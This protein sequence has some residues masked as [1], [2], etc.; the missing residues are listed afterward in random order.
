[1]TAQDQIQ[2]RIAG[3]D[4]GADDFVVK[5]YDLYEVIAR[6][7][8][9]LRRI[10]GHVSDLVQIGNI[11][12]NQS[13]KQV[14]I[15]EIEVELTQKEFHLLELLIL[16]RGRIISRESIENSLYA[17]D[18]EVS[19][20]VIQVYIHNLRRK[21]GKNIVRTVQGFGYIMDENY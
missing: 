12:V 16:N 9:V 2:E 14:F 11:A 21:L 10:S 1:M 8:A 13:A 4:A 5:P 18:A 17:Y 6:V 7:Q 15:N 3:L 19:S 20:N